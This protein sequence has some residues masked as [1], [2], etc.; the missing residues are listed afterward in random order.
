M[1]SRVVFHRKERIK[2]HSFGATAPF[3]QTQ[4]SQLARSTWTVAAAKKRNTVPAASDVSSDEGFDMMLGTGTPEYIAT[5]LLGIF[6]GFVASGVSLLI[7][8][9]LLLH[10]ID[11]KINLALS[12]IYS[13]TLPPRMEGL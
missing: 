6:T 2:H 3:K 10:R 5:G 11:P 9:H 8:V 7:E 1:P 4:S 13:G 12:F